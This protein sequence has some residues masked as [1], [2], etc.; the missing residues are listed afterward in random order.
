MPDFE[1]ENSIE[2]DVCGVDEA[3]RGPWAGPVVAGAVTLDI[4]KVSQELIKNLND[5]KKLSKK[6]R[7]MLYDLLLIE[8]EKGNVSIGVGISE[9]QEIDDINILQATFK[10]MIRAY[11]NMEFK[12]NHSLIDGNKTPKDFPTKATAIIKGDSKSLSISAA[13]IIAK[14][15]RD[16]IM[17]EL[18][19][20]YPMYLWDKNAG[21]GT[22]AHI[23][24]LK[25]HGITS[26]HR[27]SYKPIK[28]LIK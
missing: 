9:A 14:V 8:K 18:S 10:A 7:E 13:S 4:N 26:H 28:A 3:G 5:S 11:D 12:T 6:K 20:K 15:T 25:I 21:Y 16:N 19:E 1:I 23:E 24:A 2:G 22:K 17:Q 27:K